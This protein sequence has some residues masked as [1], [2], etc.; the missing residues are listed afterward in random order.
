MEISKIRNYKKKNKSDER[1][2]G[3]EGLTKGPPMRTT[4]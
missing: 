3:K 1:V 4:Y 2:L